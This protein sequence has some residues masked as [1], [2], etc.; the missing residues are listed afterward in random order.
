MLG[1]GSIKVGETDVPTENLFD[2][3]SSLED[4]KKQSSAVK[5]TVNQLELGSLERRVK[6]L[7]REEQRLIERLDKICEV[8]LLPFSRSVI[9][10]LIAWFEL[11]YTTYIPVFIR[12]MNF[13]EELWRRGLSKDVD[14]LSITR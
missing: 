4:M 11:P 12:M 14:K 8:R 9:L 6:Q 3:E 5:E 7:M 1:K 2:L 13:S 10:Q